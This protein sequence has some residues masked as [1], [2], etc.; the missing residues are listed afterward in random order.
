MTPE[1]LAE[2]RHYATCYQAGY[3]HDL[4]HNFL[5]HIDQQAARIAE[6]EKM[7]AELE[8]RLGHEQVVT[9]Q[10]REAQLQG[11]IREL[12]A[13]VT[14]LKEIAEDERAYILSANVMESTGVD[15]F[16]RTEAR[17]QLTEKYPEAFK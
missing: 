9:M 16:L 17:R 10:N 3:V 2:A 15:E 4:M 12:E 5:A 6:L 13:Q 14:A 11:Y 7:N 8:A 1:E